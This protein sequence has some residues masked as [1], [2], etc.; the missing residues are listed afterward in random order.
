M[1]V[2]WEFGVEKGRTQG[3]CYPRLRLTIPPTLRTLHLICT[4]DNYH[5]FSLFDA[6]CVN[7]TSFKKETEITLTPSDPIT[8]VG[9]GSWRWIRM[10]MS[11]W[12][13]RAMWPVARGKWRDW[14]MVSGVCVQAVSGRTG[15]N[16]SSEKLSVQS[17]TEWLQNPRPSTLSYWLKRGCR[18]VCA[19]SILTQSEPK[20]KNVPDRAR[21]VLEGSHWTTELLFSA[22]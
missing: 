9:L 5:S 22:F 21:A 8:S 2:G 18:W 3:S 20:R 1:G 13:Q 11:L 17:L 10:W 19:V 7:R 14:V 6:N 15:R 16:F 12:R 4:G